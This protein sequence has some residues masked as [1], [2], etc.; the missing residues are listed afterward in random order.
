MNLGK[1]SSLE[2][3]LLLACPALQGLRHELNLVPGPDEQDDWLLHR[4]G[5]DWYLERLE[6][7]A[8]KIKNGGRHVAAS[9]S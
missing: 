1:D 5:L 8:L 6:K 3:H 7:V 2:V 9:E 4:E